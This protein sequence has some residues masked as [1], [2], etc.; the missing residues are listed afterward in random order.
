MLRPPCSWLPYQQSSACSH[1]WVLCGTPNSCSQME[2]K[3]HLQPNLG[4]SVFCFFLLKGRVGRK[5]FHDVS[6]VG[7]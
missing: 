4:C 2:P 5:Y 7:F 6:P 1:T 3:L